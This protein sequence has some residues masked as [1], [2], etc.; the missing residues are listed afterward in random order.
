[1]PAVKLPS[2]EELNKNHYALAQSL[3]VTGRELLE[4]YVEGGRRQNGSAITSALEMVKAG[5][6]LQ[7]KIFNLDN[8]RDKLEQAPFEWSMNGGSRP[9][10]NEHNDKNIG[11]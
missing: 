10:G 9:N 3:I 11:V 2:K 6:M 7:R 1:M 5:I 4:V 8:E